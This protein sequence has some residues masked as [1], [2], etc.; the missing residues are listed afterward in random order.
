MEIK[1]IN[2]IQDKMAEAESIARNYF[3]QGL[4]CSE[5]VYLAFLDVI[6]P[7]ISRE[8]ACLA[9]GFGGGMGHTK[10]NCGAVSGAVM[11]LGAVIGRKN[12]LEK[13]NPEERISELQ[14][15]YDT[16]GKMIYEIE[17]YPSNIEVIHYS[18]YDFKIRRPDVIY[19]HNPYDNWNHVTSVHPDYYAKNLCQ[20]TEELVYVP[21]FILKEIDPKNQAA[22]NG[23]KHFC[24]LP[25]TIYAN[26]V[27]LQSEDMKQIYVNEFVKAAAENGLSGSYI[28]RNIQEKK[29]YLGYP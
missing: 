6:S 27:I 16:V 2:I 29:F 8:S 15:I 13:E 28:D 10:N 1:D 23:M 22:I 4:N 26:K 5:C 11:A 20:F 24:F 18:D 19:I 12:P 14:P 21:Y 9:S 25:G 7:D 3:R 17:E